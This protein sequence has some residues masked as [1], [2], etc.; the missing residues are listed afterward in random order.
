MQAIASCCNSRHARPSFCATCQSSFFFPPSLEFSRPHTSTLVLSFALRY[1][2]CPSPPHLLLFSLSFSFAQL[3]TPTLA[4]YPLLIVHPSVPSPSVLPSICPSV[5]SLSQSHGPSPTSS[6]LNSSC[7]HSLTPLPS[8]FFD[9]PS[10]LPFLFKFRLHLRPVLAHSLPLLPIRSRSLPFSDLV[11]RY[12]CLSLAL[13][14]LF[15]FEFLP[16]FSA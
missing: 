12:L 8:S 5:H 14:C 3:R 4:S 16:R 6:L 11:C 15:G 7:S 9:C 10:P 1:R 13:T 2:F